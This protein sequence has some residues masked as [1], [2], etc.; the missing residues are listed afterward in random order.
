MDMTM[1]MPID[2]D[3]ARRNHAIIVGYGRV[4]S[5]IGEV[6][7][8][9]G[10]PFVAV[11]RD[12]VR[13]E[14][15]RQRGVHTIFGDAAGRGG[16]LLHAGIAGARLLIVTAPEPIRARLVVDEAR[17]LRPDIPIVVRVHTEA[18]QQMFRKLGVQRILLGERELAFGMARYA[19]ASMRGARA[20]SEADV[21]NDG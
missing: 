18:D 21:S 1:E 3:V 4:G 20:R 7:K 14:Q 12:R 17:R 6:L 8:G 13:V 11:D 15:L 19:I 5:A 10:L 16:V 9:E 2:S